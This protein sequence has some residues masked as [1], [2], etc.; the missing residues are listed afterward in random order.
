MGGNHVTMNITRH[1][2]PSR[3]VL[4]DNTCLSPLPWA[5]L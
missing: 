1:M 4:G 5:P 3:Q 2:F